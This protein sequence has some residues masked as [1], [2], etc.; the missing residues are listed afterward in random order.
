ME[1]PSEALPFA[2]TSYK[3]TVARWSNVSRKTYVSYTNSQW[4]TSLPITSITFRN[5]CLTFYRGCESW[6]NMDRGTE[7]AGL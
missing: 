5:I 6:R 1:L 7:S 3:T 4:P 2:A